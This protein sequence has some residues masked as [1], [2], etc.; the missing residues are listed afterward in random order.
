M[1]PRAFV[2][3][4]LLDRPFPPRQYCPQPRRLRRRRHDLCRRRCE[5]FR[6]NESCYGSPHEDS[7]ETQP[8]TGLDTAMHT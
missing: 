7:R 5:D 2:L 6:L 3:R 4:R 8:R 1:R